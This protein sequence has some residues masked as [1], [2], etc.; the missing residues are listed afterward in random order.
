MSVE[1]GIFLVSSAGGDFG[2]SA[3]E[4]IAFSTD[5]DVPISRFMPSWRYGFLLFL[6]IVGFKPKNLALHHQDF[7]VEDI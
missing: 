1:S 3:I 6:K 7:P 4:M 2:V 5:S